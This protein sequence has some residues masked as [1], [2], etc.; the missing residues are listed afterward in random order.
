MR[1]D[2]RTSR[3]SFI[4]GIAV[5]TGGFICPTSFAL[6][7]DVTAGKKL[8]IACIGVGG[9]GVSDLEGAA[10]GQRSR[11]ASAMSMPR[12]SPKPRPSIPNA[13]PVPRFPQDAR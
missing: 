9:K 13:Q 8:G 12:I 6:K 4:K 5:T 7:D 3:R 1:L 2:T 10:E 11:R